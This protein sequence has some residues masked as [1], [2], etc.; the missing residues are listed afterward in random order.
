MDKDHLV[1]AVLDRLD[2]K[3]K[4]KSRGGAIVDG[5]RAIEF[6]PPVNP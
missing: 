6:T 2:K 5:V 1:T 3:N 4:A